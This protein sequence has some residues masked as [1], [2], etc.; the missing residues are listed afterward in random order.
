MK[1]GQVTSVGDDES[2]ASVQM[3]AAMMVSGGALAATG[4]KSDQA[5]KSDNYDVGFVEEVA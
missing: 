2:R 3:T 1:S 5:G 4:V